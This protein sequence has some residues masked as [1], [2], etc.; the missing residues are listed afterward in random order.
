MSTPTGEDDFLHELEVEVGQELNLTES[1]RPEE[2]VGSPIA[3]WPFDP[4]DAEREETGLRGLLGAVK[5]LED[6]SR[7]GHGIG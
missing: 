6:D 7:P 2:V 4:A 5:A 3:E 1:S